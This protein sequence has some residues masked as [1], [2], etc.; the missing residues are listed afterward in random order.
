MLADVGRLKGRL[1]ATVR[2]GVIPTAVAATPWITEAFRNL[3]PAAGVQVLTLP[4]REIARMLTE[5]EVDAGLTYLDDETPPGTRR[6]E[7]YRERYFLLGPEDLE[8]MSRPQVEWSD[9][10]KL[11]LCALTSQ[12][13]HR[14]I[15][16]SKM[17]AHRATFAPI[18]EADTVGALY[19]HLGRNG[20]SAI[21]SHPW[22]SALGIP[23]GMTATP[24][25]PSGAS[26]AVGLITADRARTSVLSDAIMSAAET[27]DVR[28]QIDRE[29]A[30]LLSGPASRSPI[31]PGA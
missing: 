28:H 5:F 20:L 24:M 11:P 25:A 21:V 16:E 9:A 1:T 29:V 4:S 3:H 10:A 12:M 26:P 31:R 13:R 22:L 6:L 27:A 8:L 18:I 30:E 17:A 19:V 7:L 23:A 2:L 14:R 15:L